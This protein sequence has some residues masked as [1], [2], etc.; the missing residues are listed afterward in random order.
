MARWAASSEMA[1]S[2]LVVVVN[3]AEA[4]YPLR[5][6]PTFSD[7]NWISMGGDQGVDGTVGAMAVDGAGNVYIGGEFTAVKP[8][9]YT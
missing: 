3:D 4:V 7:A 8:G 5:I 1:D 2:A 6:D 9:D